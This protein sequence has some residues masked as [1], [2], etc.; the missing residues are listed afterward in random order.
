MKI[1][2]DLEGKKTYI[3]AVLWIC[4]ALSGLV[5]GQLDANAALQAILTGLGF[6]GLR[7]AISKAEILKF[8]LQ[9]F[10]A[11]KKVEK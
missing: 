3:I 11:E 4:Y 2:L 8:P 7:S 9:D 10:P 1:N 5:I 6:I